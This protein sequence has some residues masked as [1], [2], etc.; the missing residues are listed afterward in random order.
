M[1][2]FVWF[3]VMP[4]AFLDIETVL[5]QIIQFSIRLLFSSNLPIDGTLSAATAQSKNGPGS[6]GNKGVLCIPQSSSITRNSTSECL[7]SYP[8]H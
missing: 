8:G 2:L 6:D 1:F 3:G 4:N 5:F 7:V